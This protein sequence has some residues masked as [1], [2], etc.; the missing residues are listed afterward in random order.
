MPDGEI[1]YPQ[2][3]DSVK[4]YP[5][6]NRIQLEWVI[7]DPKVTS[8]KIFYE[9]GGI[10]ES[11]TVA[12]NAHSDYFNDTIR[13][14][15]PDLEE[16]TYAFKIISY[17]DFGHSS[18]TVEAE[19]S[20]Y[21]AIYESALVNRTLKSIVYDVNEG[22]TLEW[23][24]ADDA[25]IAVKLA[26]T[27][28]NGNNRTIFVADSVNIT[29]IP[30]FK[31]SEPLFYSTMYKPVPAA[32]DT[33]Y[34]QVVEE[35]IPYYAN[36]TNMLKNPGAPFIKGDMVHDN[37]FYAA[38]DWIANAAAAANG[39]VDNLKSNSLT[40]W[41]W[42]GYS[43]LTDI[44]NGKLYQTVE[45]EAGTYRFDAFAYSTSNAINKAY[46]AVAAG[47]DLPDIDN[48]SQ[49]LASV[50]VPAGVTEGS[51]SKPTL[52]VEFTITEKTNVSLGFLGNIN[53]QQETAF[54][55]VE[56]WEKR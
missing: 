4:T 15:I 16:T 39:N 25:E 6:K 10:Q 48:V 47:N 21:G 2:K 20:A 17:D 52:S 7:V 22:L 8:C 23:F 55:K 3:A 43:P 27:D 14:I 34:V 30:D 38:A 45:L 24:E 50:P 56:L 19:E 1:I 37:R 40:M 53:S 51:A 28:I 46:V 26:Y 13:V 35:K 5:G 33:F 54:R 18:I 36:I 41:T 49:A 9:Q 32:I 11:T 29:S 42:G 12:I 31:I 44:V